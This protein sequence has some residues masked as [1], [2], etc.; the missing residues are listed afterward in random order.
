MDLNQAHILI[1]DDHQLIVNGLE[2]VIQSFSTSIQI[3]HCFNA[4]KVLE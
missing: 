1:I 4:S 3:S 2:N